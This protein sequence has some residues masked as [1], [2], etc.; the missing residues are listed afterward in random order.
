MGMVFLFFT[1]PSLWTCGNSK[2][3]FGIVEPSVRRCI[4]TISSVSGITEL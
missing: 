4:L 3:L 2:F 1:S